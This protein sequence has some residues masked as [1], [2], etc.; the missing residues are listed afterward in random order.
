[1]LATEHANRLI[2][3]LAAL[4]QHADDALA[5]VTALG[6]LNQGEAAR[7]LPGMTHS[8]EA[9][10]LHCAELRFAAKQLREALP[11]TDT[12]QPRLI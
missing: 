5:D 2:A 8:L 9:I 10:Q 3:R 6:A 12:L 7:W 4:A 11:S 1:M